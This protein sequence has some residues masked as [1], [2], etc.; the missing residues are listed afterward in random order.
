MSD[1]IYFT[2]IFH[3]L[4]LKK[5]RYGQNLLKYLKILHFKWAWV[6]TSEQ[7]AKKIENWYFIH[8]IYQNFC[9]NFKSSYLLL[10]QFFI[11]QSIKF[12]FQNLPAII[13]NIFIADHMYN[14]IKKQIYRR[15]KKRKN[16]A[17]YFYLWK[18]TK[19]NS[20]I[21]RLT[22]WGRN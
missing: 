6:S 18:R 16:Y 19:F 21:V 15:V 7:P 12:L 13:F 10:S 9:L 8:K 3:Y 22:L 5:I 14:L 1:F 11:Q 4:P 17:D 20:E 2:P